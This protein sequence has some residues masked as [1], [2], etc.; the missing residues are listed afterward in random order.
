MADVGGEAAAGGA[1]TWKRGEGVSQRGIR[2]RPGDGRWA[3][4]PGKGWLTGKGIGEIG[5][6]FPGV[7]LACDDG[8]ASIVESSFFGDEGVELFHFFVIFVE[9]LEERGLCS[10]GA[11]NASEPEIPFNSFKISKVVQ[12]VLYPYRCSFAG[13]VR[14]SGLA[15]GVG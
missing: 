11:F 5:V 3:Q 2:R 9:E 10:C 7:G 1:E 12:Q 8:E 15:V 14:L 4:A 13:C 6:D